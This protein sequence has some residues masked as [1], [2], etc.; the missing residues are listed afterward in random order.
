M[1]DWIGGPSIYFF[2]AD[3]LL[4]GIDY[5]PQ[6]KSWRPS[7]IIEN[8]IRVHNQSQIASVP[9]LNGT[10]AWIYYQDLDE[11]IREL[12]LDDYRD[13]TWR[14]GSV[15]PLGIGQVGSGIGVTR[16]VN[17]TDE[18]E[19]VFFQLANGAIGG[20]MYMMSAW[21]PDYYVIEGTPDNVPVGASITVATVTEGAASTILLAYVAN[22]GFLNVQTRGTTDLNYAEFSSP[23]QLVEGDGQSNIGLAA[24]GSLGVASIYFVKGQEILELSS[25]NSTGGNWTTVTL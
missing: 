5:V 9:W 16:W 2:T 15:G 7:S 11:Q 23:V 20:R 6:N 21:T 1:L 8:K 10:S 13:S 3:Y 14:D 19:E 25:Q 22:S 12:G 18:V 24:V 17:G 4:S